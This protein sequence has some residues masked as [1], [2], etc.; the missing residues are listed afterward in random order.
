MVY[1]RFVCACFF[2]NFFETER[3]RDLFSL[4]QRKEGRK[5]GR[6]EGFVFV[7]FVSKTLNSLLKKFSPFFPVDKKKREF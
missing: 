3:E 6:K 7:F 4:L 1:Q 2:V 5:D